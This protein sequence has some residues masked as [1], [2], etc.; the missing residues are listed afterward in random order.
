MSGSRQLQDKVDESEVIDANLILLVTNT[1]F[2]GNQSE[3][4]QYCQDG[5]TSLSQ[6]RGVE[7]GIA[8]TQQPS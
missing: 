4:A 6:L 8:H 5:G 3:R 2:H 1:G 7:L